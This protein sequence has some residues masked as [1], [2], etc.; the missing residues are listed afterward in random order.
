MKHEF[1]KDYWEHHW[2]EGREAQSETP[3]QPGMEG[4]PGAGGQAGPEQPNPYLSRE[5]A[6]L[7]PGTALDAGCGTGAEALWLAAHG[8]QVTGA[9]ISQTALEQAA[10]RA[11][12]QELDGQVTWVEADLVSWQPEHQFDLVT[13]HYAHPAIPQLAFYQRVAQWVAPGGALLIVGHRHDGGSAGHGEHPPAE[14]TVTVADVAA[15]LDPAGW[16]ID[17]A[18]EKM[19]TMLGP[20]G[21]AHALNDVVVRATRIS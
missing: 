21:T 15:V 3:G 10:A 12:A 20:D 11:A 6:G 19:R 17:T 13:T 5:T 16:R 1:D 7:T 8:W 18:E 4:K 2:K 9:D 14:A